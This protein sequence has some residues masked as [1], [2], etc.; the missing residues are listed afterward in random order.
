MDPLYACLIALV[1]TLL[2]VQGV[3]WRWWKDAEEKLEH[4]QAQ[5]NKLMNVATAAVSQLGNVDQ[6]TAKALLL[7]EMRKES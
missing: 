7:A 3:F 1:V 4:T 5:K 6:K 2:V